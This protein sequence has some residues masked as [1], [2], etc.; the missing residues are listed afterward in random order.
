MMIAA[1]LEKASFGIAT[2]VLFSQ[3]RIPAAVVVFGVIDLT[4]G[5]LFAIAWRS[6][7]RNRLA[8]FKRA[9]A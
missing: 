2:L 7:R 4:L 9:E 5:T 1:I 6:L 3:Q 8:S